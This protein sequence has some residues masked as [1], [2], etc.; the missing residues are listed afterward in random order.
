MRPFVPVL[1]VAV[2]LA[3]QAWAAPA[4]AW[5][6]DRAASKVAF[7]SSFDGGAFSGAFR[8]WDAAIRR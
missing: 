7:N 3:S 4:P 8:R 5:T 1:A 6:V 2:V